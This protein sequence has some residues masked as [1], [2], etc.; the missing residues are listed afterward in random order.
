M[1]AKWAWVGG[2]LTVLLVT[3]CPPKEAETGGG[4][5]KP[6]DRQ[7]T[8][9]VATPSVGQKAAPYS[10]APRTTPAPGKPVPTVPPD[11]KSRI[12]GAMSRPA[13]PLAPNPGVRSE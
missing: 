9:G 7:R 10:G 3:G 6:D 5:G 11:P 12:P 2:A 4:G 8:E 13:T 1:A